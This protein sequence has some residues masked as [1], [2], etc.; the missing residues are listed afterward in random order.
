[1]SDRSAA[2]LSLQFNLRVVPGTSYDELHSYGAQLMDELLALEE[3]NPGTFTDSTVSTDALERTLTVDLLILDASSPAAALQEALDITR[4]AIHA[5]GG[6]TP[7]WPT[8]SEQ[9]EQ[10]KITKAHDLVP[11]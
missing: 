2:F 6:A 7:G 8:I 5:A 9:P 10:V 1:M 11:A 4:T 3:C